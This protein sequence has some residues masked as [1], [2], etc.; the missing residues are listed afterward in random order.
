M[1]I[2]DIVL[3]QGTDKRAA[4]RFEIAIALAK[5]HEA[6]LIGVLVKAEP[7]APGHWWP[8]SGRAKMA[9]W[10]SRMERAHGE[11]EAAFTARLRD[12]GVTGE[13]RVMHGEPGEVLTACARRG[14]LTIIGQTD[15]DEPVYGAGLPHQLVLGAGAPVLIVPYAGNFKTVGRRVLLA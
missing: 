13:W 9:E 6:R 3:H 8:V 11:L 15:P 14:D 7:G 10:L 4:A 2:R 1:A 12:E 5:A